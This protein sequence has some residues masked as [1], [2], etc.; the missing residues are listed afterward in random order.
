MK[1]E[2]PYKKFDKENGEYKRAVELCDKE[3]TFEQKEIYNS[4]RDSMPLVV[5]FMTVTF[6]IIAGSMGLILYCVLAENPN[7]F[8]FLVGELVTF[9]PTAF[10][11]LCFYLDYRTAVKNWKKIE[12]GIIYSIQKELQ[13]EQ[14]KI[15]EEYYKEHPEKFMA[16]YG[17]KED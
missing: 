4:A 17:L 11:S 5:F 13:D 9:I 2:V 6:G 7:I 15:A 10:V 14:K 16:I 1:F 12:K 8:H 3:L